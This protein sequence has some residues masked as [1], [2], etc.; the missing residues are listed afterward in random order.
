MYDSNH[1]EKSEMLDWEKKPTIIKTNY[2]DAKDYFE[3]LVKAANTYVQNAGG[4]TA[5]RN[6]YESANNM[7]DIGYKIHE[8]IANLASAA[9]DG[10][11]QEHAANTM[12]KTNQFDAMAAQI[13]ASP[14]PLRNSWPRRRT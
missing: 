14:T 10:A 9:A 3:A 2:N 8:Y 1:F 7:E 11:T 13:K 5:G 12:S 6:K 4:G